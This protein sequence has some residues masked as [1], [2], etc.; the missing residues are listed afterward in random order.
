[1]KKPLAS[2]N[3]MLVAAMPTASVRTMMTLFAGVLSCC[4]MPNATSVRSRSNMLA[5]SGPGDALPVLREVVGGAPR[6]RL[7]GQGRVARAARPHHR[8]AEDAE[9]GRFVGESPAIDDVG[10]D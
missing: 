4:L 2:E 6:Q 9:V 10:L 8:R 5:L 3:E 1:M 7:R